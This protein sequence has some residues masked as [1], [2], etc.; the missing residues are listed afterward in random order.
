[1]SVQNLARRLLPTLIAG[2]FAGSAGAAGFALL[3]Q[4]ASGIGNAFAGT[5]ASAEDASTIF[6]NPAG[7]AFLPAGKMHFAGS[8]DLVRPSATFHNAGN[9][10]PATLGLAPPGPFPYGGNG[11]D[12]GSWNIVPAVYFAMPIND[13][14][15][16]GVGVGAPFGLK[17]EYDKDWV[18]RFQATRSEIK[19]INVNPSISFRPNERMA[20]GFGINYQRLEAD[21]RNQVVTGAPAEA[22]GKI[23]GDDNA[24]GY[25]LGA[26]F[27]LSQNM[28]LGLAYRS[29]VK[30]DLKGNF[31]LDAF[32]GALNGD[33]QAKVKLPDSFT[34]SVAQK[35][36][37]KWEMLGDLQWTGWSKLQELAIY[38]TSG[39][40]LTRE[41]LEWRNT[42]R[43]AFG[44]NYLYS[45]AW[46]FR[47]GLAYDQSPVGDTHR[48]SRLP[49]NDRFW[50]SAGAQWKPAGMPGAVD[51]GLAYLFM[52]KPTIN[53]NQ[54][55][56]ATKGLLSGDYNGANVIILGAQYS[57]SF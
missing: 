27:Q 20:F 17:T 5:A 33:I 39:P 40:L 19:T 30:Y 36:S 29:A 57:Q 21:L 37:D 3:E 13:K 9:S 1:M 46:K 42:V 8:I 56:P 32:G 12:I 45:Q 4:N 25:N 34:I 44:G 53:N 49:D 23:E 28:R 41:V 15:S 52:R 11:G 24:W 2:S 38:R 7:M 6:S 47:F 50:L 14:I 31:K 43:V 26:I 48:L 51:F 54:G 35:L 22:A 10:S 16:V 55:S 18:G